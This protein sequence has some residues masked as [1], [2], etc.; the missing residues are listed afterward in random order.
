MSMS[1]YP[2]ESA[3]LTV[4]YEDRAGRCFRALSIFKQWFCI[5]W[6]V[7]REQAI[8]AGS[9]EYQGMTGLPTKGKGTGNSTAVETAGLRWLSGESENEHRLPGWTKVSTRL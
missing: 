2:I 1:V 3:S 4:F 5:S 9:M 7:Y 6:P 8:V